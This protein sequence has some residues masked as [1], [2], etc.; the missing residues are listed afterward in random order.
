MDYMERRS[1]NIQVPRN[2][3]HQE[4]LKNSQS[5]RSEMATPERGN[6]DSQN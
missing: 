5:H 1:K 6:R 2:N 3:R 4:S